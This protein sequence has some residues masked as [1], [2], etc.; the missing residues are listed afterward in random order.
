MLTGSIIRRMRLDLMSNAEETDGSY[1]KNE[2]ELQ[3]GYKSATPGRWIAHPR[4]LRL[5]TRPRPPLNPDGSRS[6]SFTR[7]SRSCNMPSIVFSNSHST[8][9]IIEKI[10]NEAVIPLF[11]KLHPEPS[12]WDLSLI[13]L[14]VTN[15]VLSATDDKN[16][17]GRD[18]GR[19][20][21]RQESVLKEWKVDDI[22]TPPSDH[23]TETAHPENIHTLAA[24]DRSTSGETVTRTDHDN[25]QGGSEDTHIATQESYVDESAWDDENEGCDM[26][27]AC[28]ACGAFMPSFAMVAHQRFH[29]LPD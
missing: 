21:R 26:A 7:M 1:E 28:K 5:T 27:E 2:V 22:D 24:S 6:R 8:E 23:D 9:V 10:V 14:C 15:M 29:A 3:Q 16:G 4:T 18:I 20:F 17:S 13:N 12:G 11:R 25:I 19:M